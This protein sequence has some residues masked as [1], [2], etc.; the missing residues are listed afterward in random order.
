MSAAPVAVEKPAADQES[1]A[2]RLSRGPLPLTE[3][4]HHAIRIASALRDL[5]E[6]GLVY[7]AVSSHLIL[8]APAGAT[9]RT[10]GSLAHFGE[11]SADIKAFGAVLRE[12]LRWAVGPEKLR[13]D[14]AAL[15]AQCQEA[16]PDMQ[17]VL[18]LLRLLRLR[19]NLTRCTPLPVRRQESAATKSAVR[20]RVHLNLHW[21]P[22]LHLVSLALA[23]R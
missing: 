21:K 15:A 10:G 5:H 1:L 16:T 2:E 17:Q 6:Y 22:L 8:L 9:L 11:P 12:M 18:T 20:L 14:L 13:A 23:G 3:A 7:G 19:Q 4:L